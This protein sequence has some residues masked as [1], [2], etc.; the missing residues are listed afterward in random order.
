MPVRI[1]LQRWGTK[2]LPVYRIV[3]ADSRSPRDGKCLERL[4][5]YHVIADKY[6]KKTV[7]FKLPRIKY[8][9]A[10]GAQPT[11]RIAYLLGKAGILPERYQH[12][13][14]PIPEP[15]APWPPVTD[16]EGGEDAETE[17]ADAAAG[18]AD[19][20]D[21]KAAQAPEGVRTFSTLCG[22]GSGSLRPSK[23]LG[24]RFL[25]G[26]LVPA[27]YAPTSMKPNTRR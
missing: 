17:T 3:A 27:L 9:L 13:L 26:M 7:N 15:K 20:G 6:G 19:G 25:S 14:K 22:G 12:K 10:V 21:V 1:R 11:K 2:G 23:D 24:V 4:G 8:W 18:D 16:E 5:T